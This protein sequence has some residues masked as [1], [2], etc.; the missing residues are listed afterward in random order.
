MRAVAGLFP[1][2]AGSIRLEDQG[3]ARSVP[4]E[5]HYFGHLNAVKSGLTVEENA[6][7]WCRYLGGETDLVFKALELFGLLA[8]RDIPAGYLSAGQKRRLG[9]SRLLVAKRAVWLL[10]EPATSLDVASQ[11]VLA[12]IVNE[13]IARGGIVLA[14]THA[15]LGL[16]PATE[17][18]LA[19][20]AAA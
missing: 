5:S 4:E 7:F 18:S 19:P 11:A 3:K 6:S 14:A 17:L 20:R 15:P 9:L 8:L 16:A 13:H 1:Q 10:D 2:S 12:R